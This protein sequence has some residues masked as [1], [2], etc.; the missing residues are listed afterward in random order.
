MR[1]FS[2]ALFVLMDDRRQANRPRKS[3]GEE[4]K[5]YEKK[6]IT[7]EGELA[8]EVTRA[9]CGIEQ[10]RGEGLEGLMVKGYLQIDPRGVSLSH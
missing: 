8:G 4:I 6:V 3:S 5:T 2:V 9:G 7:P 1:F 10:G